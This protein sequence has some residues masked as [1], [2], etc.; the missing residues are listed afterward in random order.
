MQN[1]IA[2][3]LSLVFLPTMAFADDRQQQE[4]TTLIA[5]HSHAER[6]FNLPLND[7]KRLTVLFSTPTRPRGTIIMLPGGTGDIGLQQDGRIGQGDNF[8]V[9]TRDLWNKHGYA[10]LIPDTINHTNLRG[11]RSSSAYARLVE[12]LA[13]FAHQPESG[14]VFLL[15]TSQGSIAAVNAAAHALPSSIAAV[16]L[17]ESVSVMGGSGETVFSATPQQ[18]R[19]PVLVVVNRDDLCNV[20]PP[21]SARQIAAAMTASGDV[22]VLTVSGGAT[23]SKKNCGSLT[24]H[25]YFRIE[26]KVIDAISR[27]LDTH[28]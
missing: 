15:G 4:I 14:P 16:V 13:A 5:D 25:G 10:V 22:H 11:R 20:A 24:P 27:W 28:S 8:V 6:V 12:E 17:T 7:G 9:R 2:T 21:Q 23:R 18:V 1:T 3:L 26:D 19:A